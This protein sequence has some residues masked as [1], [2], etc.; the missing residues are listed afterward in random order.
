MLLYSP[1][2]TILECETESLQNLSHN[3]S[4]MQRFIL[5]GNENILKKLE[6]VLCQ[7]TPW[8]CI[9]RAYTLTGDTEF[10]PLDEL[11][12][13]IRLISGVSLEDKKRLEQIIKH[14]ALLFQLEFINES[15]F[16]Y[17][18]KQLFSRLKKIDKSFEYDTNILE[19]FNSYKKTE[20]KKKNCIYILLSIILLLL[21]L[22]ILSFIGD[23]VK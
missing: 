5:F 6:Y 9:H 8:H 13:S 2:S 18:M 21:F 12:Q 19:E 10:T 15:D 1:W 16:Y 11:L 22:I 23:S 4:E 20:K 17:E 14:Y 7:M 3:G